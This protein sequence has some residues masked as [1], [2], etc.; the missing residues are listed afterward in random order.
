MGFQ[1]HKGLVFGVCMCVYQK[2]QN[3]RLLRNMSHDHRQER[4]K[5]SLCL[6][7]S[8]AVHNKFSLID[9]CEVWGRVYF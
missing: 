1:S 6:I 8:E 7:G 3:S 2:K 4:Q 9:K 5:P